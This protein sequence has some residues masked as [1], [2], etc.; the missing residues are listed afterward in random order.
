MTSSTPRHEH[1]GLVFSP[2]ALY[3]PLEV[4]SSELSHVDTILPI[5]DGSTF[6][7]ALN[8]QL[9]EEDDEDS[10]G[11]WVEVT[12]RY[13]MVRVDWKFMRQYDGPWPAWVTVYYMRD[14]VA[15]DLGRIPLLDTRNVKPDRMVLKGILVVEIP[16]AGR[17]QAYVTADFVDTNNIPIPGYDDSWTLHNDALPEGV[18]RENNWF[19]IHPHAQPGEFSVRG[20]G[21]DGLEARATITLVA[22]AAAAKTRDASAQHLIFSPPAAYPPLEL[23]DSQIVWIHPIKP[24]IGNPTFH[25]ALNGEKEGGDGIDVVLNDRYGFVGVGGSFMK[26]YNG[27]WPAWVDVCQLKDGVN[28]IWGRLPLLNTA[29]ATPE[30]MVVERASVHQIPESGTNFLTF[31][32]SFVD[33]NN[34]PIP[35]FGRRWAPKLT[36]PVPGVVVEGQYLMVSSAAEPGPLHVRIT[37][38]L[39]FEGG[40]TITLLAA[41]AS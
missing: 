36:T 7:Y 26:S 10:D 11:I 40:A 20:T 37:T 12:N 17:E 34:I 33:G 28:T 25:Y 27:P 35:G 29:A 8:G 19:W 32:V 18:T 30:R 21:P 31:N 5:P 13:G 1:I 15:K 6:R 9:V 41:P 2:P 22:A 3:P 16:E 39:G 23:L 4:G 14:G 24:V 38:D